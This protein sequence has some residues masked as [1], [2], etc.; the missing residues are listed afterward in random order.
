M[1]LIDFIWHLNDYYS[2]IVSEITTRSYYQNERSLPHILL[3]LKKT[4]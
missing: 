1:Y 2:I 4:Y 3:E